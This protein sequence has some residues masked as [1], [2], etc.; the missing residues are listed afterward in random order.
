VGKVLFACDCPHSAVEALVQSVATPGDGVSLLFDRPS[1]KSLV[2][3]QGTY[4][5]AYRAQGVPLTLFSLR[6]VAGGEMRP[7]ERVIPPDGHAAG[8]RR[9]T[10]AARV[11]V[12]AIVAVLPSAALAQPAAAPGASARRQI[13][14]QSLTSLPNVSDV[15]RAGYYLVLQADSTSRTGTATIAVQNAAGSVSASLTL[16]GPLDQPSREARPLTLGGLPPSGS[17]GLALHWFRWPYRPDVAAMRR[18]CQQALGKEE[19][20]D[21]ELTD[22]ADRSAFRRLAHSGDSPLV[23]TV[24]ATGGREAF[25]YL[26]VATLATASGA[27]TNWAA[28]LGAGRYSPGIGYVSLEWEHQRRFQAAAPVEICRASSPD[29]LQCRT[30]V[31]GPPAAWNLDIGTM[32]WRYFF[33]G[34]RAAIN[35]SFARDFTRRVS[36]ADLPVY[37]LASPSAALAGGARATWRSD[38]H[39]LIVAIFVGAALGLRP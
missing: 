3:A 39:D 29:L 20:D 19:C 6:V 35:P 13:A 37:F 9:L 18:L 4:E 17:V 34:G 2:L 38:T 32:S 15:L 36:S 16:S 21:D 25:K 24:R 27:H 33:P 23:A 26:D 28:A 31:A 12:A 30:A 8:V 5:V 11:I 7:L 1:K 10:V 22:P 14:E